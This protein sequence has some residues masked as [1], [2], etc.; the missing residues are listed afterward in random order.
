[1]CLGTQS[2][3]CNSV[4]TL[5]KTIHI[6]TLN[7]EGTFCSTHNLCALLFWHSIPCSRI[8]YK[9]IGNS[10][11]I[12]RG[13]ST[14]HILRRCIHELALDLLETNRHDQNILIH[15]LRKLISN[16][17]VP[18]LTTLADKTLAPSPN[19]KLPSKQTIEE[20]ITRNQQRQSQQSDLKD[21]SSINVQVNSRHRAQSQKSN[22]KQRP[23]EHFEQRNDRSQNVRQSKF[24]Q[25]SQPQNTNSISQKNPHSNDSNQLRKSTTATSSESNNL[26]QNS[27]SRQ[28]DIVIEDDGDA[29][30]GSN[31]NNQKNIQ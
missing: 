19:L 15:N 1:M 26:E 2:Y 4:E 3:N 31:A 23:F 17:N 12:K 18:G 21:H 24:I 8:I 20:T 28:E 9:G 10:F 22:T 5:R 25:Q 7:H 13:I 30:Q 29:Q 16:K 27:N 14:S 11:Q 6:N